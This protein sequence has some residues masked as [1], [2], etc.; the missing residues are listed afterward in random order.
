MTETVDTVKYLSCSVHHREN[1][2]STCHKIY[3]NV[4]DIIIM[5]SIEIFHCMH[6]IYNKQLKLLSNYKT[7]HRYY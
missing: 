3:E 5:K 4:L 1:L 2:E 7:M 6:E